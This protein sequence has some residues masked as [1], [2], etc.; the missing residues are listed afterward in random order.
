MNIHILAFSPC[1]SSRT[2]ARAVARGLAEGNG[3]D[4]FE[5]ELTFQD[6]KAP[7]IDSG[8]VLVVSAPVYAGRIP[9]IALT[10]LREAKALGCK[11]VSVV[12]YGNR[13]YDSALLELNETLAQC[14]ITAVASGAFLAR[15]VYSPDIAAHRPDGDDERDASDLGKKAAELIA[16][17]VA[18]PVQVPGEFP[19]PP[20]M[21]PQV[22][23]KVNE[24]L[25]IRCRHC[26]MDCPTGAISKDAPWSEV[27]SELCLRCMRCVMNCPRHARYMEPKFL[28]V[29]GARLKSIP[30]IDERR[31]NETFLS[32]MP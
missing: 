9:A 21:I 29:V 28:Q 13:A 20:A 11:A 8:D 12:T 5:H 18:D 27:N 30:G 24:E 32:P 2:V 7:V 25:C 19:F 14:G 16:A 31:A 26:A 10:R 6:Y 1:G 4:V 3:A 23:P 17:G 15:H 22:L